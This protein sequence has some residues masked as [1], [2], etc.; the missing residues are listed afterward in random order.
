MFLRV[1]ISNTMTSIERLRLEILVQ[2]AK[3]RNDP[4]VSHPALETRLLVAMQQNLEIM[5]MNRSLDPSQGAP[6]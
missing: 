5:L 4:T 6:R 2:G 1:E 3:L